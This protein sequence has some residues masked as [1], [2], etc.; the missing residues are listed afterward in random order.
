[1]SKAVLRYWAYWP[2]LDSI[3]V[4]SV[5]LS[6]LCESMPSERVPFEQQMSRIIL[7]KNLK[8]HIRYL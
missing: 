7:P 6:H 2:L 8:I 5:L 1:M 4:I 3:R